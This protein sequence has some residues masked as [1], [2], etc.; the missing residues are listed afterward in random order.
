[1][2]CMTADNRSERIF[3]V[4]I[5]SCSLLLEEERKYLTN[6]ILQKG[7]LPVAMEF[8]FGGANT[9]L[10]IEIDKNKIDESD[11]VVVILGHVY[12]EI[13][14]NK[15]GGAKGTVCP[16]SAKA[17]ETYPHENCDS[18]YNKR[19]CHISFTQFEYL[20]AI[21]TQK[22]VY[23]IVN[24]NY[25]SQSDFEQKYQ[26]WKKTSSRECLQLWGEGRRKNK[27]FIKDVK[28]RAC[29]LYSSFEQFKDQC[30]HV[31]DKAVTDL[32]Q[33]ADGGLVPF[34]SNCTIPSTM[35]PIFQP[36]TFFSQNERPT[37]TQFT[38]TIKNATKFYFMARTGIT[39]LAKYTP[40]IKKAIDA[41]CECRFIILNRN[42]D[43]IHNGRYEN[44]FDKKNADTSYFYLQQLKKYN[45]DRVAVHITDFYPTFDI[46]FFESSEGKRLVVVQ[47]HFLLSHLGPDRPMFMLKETDYWYHTFKDEL[48]DMWD[49]TREME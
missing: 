46:E 47:S 38:E 22:P 2:I 42:F 32:E 33:K 45:P 20:Y 49:N 3:R 15:I 34:A 14:N 9:A 8:D 6:A 11:C 24:E 48:D 31:L 27:Q 35:P 21:H 41:G 26:E 13:I 23:V 36:I 28:Q 17:D 10:S 43:V 19:T 44:A 7:H 18:C 40:T 12:G 39:F 1:M 25:D 4:F 29:F 30:V 5:S 16:F 37:E